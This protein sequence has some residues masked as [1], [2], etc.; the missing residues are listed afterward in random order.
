EASE[1]YSLGVD[2]L[3]FISAL[4]GRGSHELEQAIVAALPPFREP[5]PDFSTTGE[6]ACLALIGRPNAG[7][8]SLLNCL[9]GT[10]RSLV[11]DKPGTTRDPV[12]TRVDYRGHSYVVVDTAGIRRRAK[13]D[14]GV[15]SASVMR[16]I[17]AI[18]RA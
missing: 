2:V 13:V 10:E 7:K 18:A 9:A 14:A 12:D 6:V 16:S 4:H 8:S 1:L 3:V 5:P 15:E 11:D 17:R